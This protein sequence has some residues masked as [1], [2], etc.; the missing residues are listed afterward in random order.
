LGKNIRSRELWKIIE[1]YGV[2]AGS[3]TAAFLAEFLRGTDFVVGG[4]NAGLR[5]AVNSNQPSGPCNESRF[6]LRQAARSQ[7]STVQPFFCALPGE[8]SVFNLTFRLLTEI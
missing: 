2:C 5:V 7:P 8:F 3:A 6:L 1:I 4:E